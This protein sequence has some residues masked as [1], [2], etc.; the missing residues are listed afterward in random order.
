MMCFSINSFAEE[1]E[2]FPTE[3]PKATKAEM[4]FTKS[5]FIEVER[6][7]CKHPRENQNDFRSCMS[8]NFNS[9][10]P[11]CKQLMSKTYSKNG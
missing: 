9:L 1:I 10:T 6:A 4:E 11:K 2:Y 8:Q 3:N 7:G 5:C